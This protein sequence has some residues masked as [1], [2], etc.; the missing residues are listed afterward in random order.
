MLLK[1]TTGVEMA[2]RSELV[3]AHE[4]SHQY[5]GNQVTIDWWNNAWLKEGLSSLYEYLAVQNTVSTKN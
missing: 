1:N 4:I 5:F 2:Q 3:L